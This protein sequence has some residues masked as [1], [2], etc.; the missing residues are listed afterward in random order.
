LKN[1]TRDQEAGHRT[2]EIF[3]TSPTGRSRHIE[4]AE[5]LTV[6][7]NRLKHLG[8]SATGDCFIVSED[9]GIVELIVHPEVQKTRRTPESCHIVRARLPR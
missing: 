2:F 5:S 3:V 8:C 9:S 4:S 6:A 1:K 7:R